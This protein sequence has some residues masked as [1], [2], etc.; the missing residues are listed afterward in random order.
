MR[1]LLAVLLFVLTSCGNASSGTDLPA[2]RDTTTHRDSTIHHDSTV[3]QDSTIRHDTVVP[4]VLDATTIQQFVKQGATTIILLRHAE[5]SSVGG[6][7]PAL[8]NEGMSRANLLSNLLSNINIDRIYSTPYQRTRQT[9]TPLAMSKQLDI[10]EYP[11]ATTA[12]QMKQKILTDATGKTIVV[13]GHSNTIP[14][15]NK[16][17]GGKPITITETDFDNFVIISMG[18][19][20]NESWHFEYGAKTN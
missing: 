1:Q 16:A 5:K 8:S 20:G 3:H 11:A 19:A 13:V 17:L 18:N 9:V 6:N 12:E 4:F 10:I 2:N 7:D 14:E 15:L